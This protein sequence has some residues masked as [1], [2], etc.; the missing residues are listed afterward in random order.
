[1]LELWCYFLHVEHDLQ[2]P[3]VRIQADRCESVR[4]LLS[5]APPVGAVG[6]ATQEQRDVELLRSISDGEDNLQTTNNK[7]QRMRSERLNRQTEQSA[8]FLF[9]VEKQLLGMIKDS[10][11]P[12]QEII[13]KRFLIGTRC[14]ALVHLTALKNLFRSVA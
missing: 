6:E 4:S 9:D 14:A 7:S 12:V 3:D 5:L 10:Y 1:M 11:F 13:S 8:L 2:D